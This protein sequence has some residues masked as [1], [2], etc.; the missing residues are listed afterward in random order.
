[1]SKRNC[2]SCGCPMG[3][4]LGKCHDCGGGSYRAGG[5]VGNETDGWEA[6]YNGYLWSVDLG[7]SPKYLK[8]HYNL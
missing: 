3:S 2:E 1:M 6:T 4:T 8:K 5:S 7:V